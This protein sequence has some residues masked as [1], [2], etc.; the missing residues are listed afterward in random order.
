M[1]SNDAVNRHD[2]DTV[3][4]LVFAGTAIDHPEMVSTDETYPGWQPACGCTPYG[5]CKCMRF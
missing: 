4:D 2:L 1:T 3:A 5:S